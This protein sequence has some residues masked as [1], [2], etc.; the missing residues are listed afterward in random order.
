MGA[1][2]V[3]AASTCIPEIVDGS[4]LLFETRSHEDLRLKLERVLTE[5]GLREKMVVQG[6]Q[7]AQDFSWYKT[8]ES[9]LRVLIE[10]AG[11]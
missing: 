7:R 9:T 1:P 5:P 10:A 6:R 4:A 8:A 11:A 2:I 3:A